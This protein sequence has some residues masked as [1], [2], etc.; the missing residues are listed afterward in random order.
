M[1]TKLILGIGILAASGVG[2]NLLPGSASE[3]YLLLRVLAA[4]CGVLLL[5][6][7]FKR[8][9][10]AV[11]SQKWVGLFLFWSLLTVFWSFD[12]AESFSSTL[13]LASITLLGVTLATQ[14]AL[15]PGAKYLANLLTAVSAVSI[16]AVYLVPDIATETVRHPIAGVKVQPSGLF[17]WN[18]DLA[19]AAAV[20]TVI[21]FFLWSRTKQKRYIAFLAVNL[22]TIV[23]ADS[24]AT[25][26][27]VIAA[28]VVGFF[29]RNKALRSLSIF[30]LVFA[31]TAVAIYG[32]ARLFTQVF[33]GL[34]RDVNLTGRTDLW[35][36]TIYQIAEHP[37]IGWGAGTNPDFVGF[38]GYDMVHSHNGYLQ[39]IFDR[40][41][42]GLVIL[43]VIC[44]WVVVPGV[45]VTEFGA[46]GMPL[47][48]LVLVANLANVYFTF[49]AL[50]MLLI[51]WL[52]F[53]GHNISRTP[54]E[55]N[56]A[57]CVEGSSSA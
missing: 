34:N 39:L 53:C 5:G 4:V 25:L 20:P 37:I 23:I 30:A 11:L 18:S 35:R 47:L 10:E 44:S 12:P 16:A 13:G 36:A 14:F 31:F 43:L 51:L 6:M 49:A 27:S 33:E 22:Y 54:F 2:A 50:P 28:L 40:G 29:V 57:S 15:I 52:S 42:I 17:A 56:T 41:L 55:P 9:V 8:L 32:P 7:N 21:C 26:L 48:T 45:R 46:I 1:F 24:V 3:N 38:L 19:L